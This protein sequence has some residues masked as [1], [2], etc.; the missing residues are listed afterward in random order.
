MG[1]QRQQAAANGRGVGRIGGVEED[2]VVLVCIHGLLAPAFAAK[3]QP[4]KGHAGVAKGLD[5]QFDHPAHGVVV[6]LGDQLGDLGRGRPVGEHVID[7]LLDVAAQRRQGFQL[8]GMADAA[9]QVDQV[10]ALQGKQVALGNHPAQAAVLHQADMG[11]VSLGHRHRRIEGAGL[12]RQGEGLLGHQLSDWLVEVAATVSYHP[13][14]VAQGKNAQGF[15]LLVGDHHAAHMLLVHQ[16]YGFAQWRL[17]PAADRLLHRQL[18]QARLQRILRAEGLGGVQLDLLVDLIEQAADPAQGKVAQRVGEGEQLDKS[19]LVEQQAEAIL[20]GQVFGTGGALTNQGRQREALAGGDFE[21][22]FLA[23][24]AAVGPLAV[25]QALL[26]DVEVF[27]GAVVGLDDAVARRIEAQLAVLHQKGQVRAFHLVEGRVLAQKLHGAVDVLHHR[28]FAGVLSVD[29]HSE[30]PARALP[31]CWPKRA[32]R[33]SCTLVAGAGF[34]QTTKSPHR[35]GF[36]AF[37]WF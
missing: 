15:E 21:G 16:P 13:A 35:A 32:P 18:A 4:G 25:H 5:T 37:R 26:D 6:E 1:G 17:R 7:Q 2:A 33:A 30:L 24:L 34:A 14:Q 8:A 28:H 19:R 29:L 31:G 27:D 11:D 10:D 3:A 23:V 22:G 9:R 12:G 36:L 20:G